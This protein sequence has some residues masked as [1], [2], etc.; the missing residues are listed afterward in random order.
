VDEFSVGQIKM[1]V[2]QM[3][4]KTRNDARAADQAARRKAEDAAKPASERMAEMVADSPNEDAGLATRAASCVPYLLPLVDGCAYGYHLLAQAPLAGAALAPFVILLRAVPFG[5][6]ILFFLFSSQSRNPSLPLLLRFNLQQ[7]IMLDIALFFPSLFA[8]LPIAEDIKAVVAE[9]ASD[10][11]FLVL[12]AC[13]VYSWATNLA[14]GKLP[15]KIPLIGSTSER[16]I[17]GP[18]DEK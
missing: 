6:L 18:F 14:T 8:L 7:A 1:K 3:Q 15:N 13:I 11:V 5:G 9:P 2:E 12:V 17:G 4:D 16:Q 10:A